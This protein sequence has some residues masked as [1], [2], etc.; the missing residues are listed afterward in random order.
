MER[1]RGLVVAPG[2]PYSGRPDGDSDTQACGY[3]LGRGL[4]ECYWALDPGSAEGWDSWTFLFDQARCGELSR[5]AGR[6]SG[7]MQPFGAPAITGS[8]E[9]WKE[10]PATHAGA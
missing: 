7:Y 5:L 3:Q 4:A 1:C 6:L 8:L 2:R 9:V 10:R